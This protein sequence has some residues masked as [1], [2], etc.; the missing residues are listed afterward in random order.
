MLEITG[1]CCN[2]MEAIEFMEGLADVVDEDAKGDEFCEEYER[3][4]NRFRYEVAKGLGRKKNVARAVAKGYC[5][6]KY[7]GKCG[8]TADEPSWSYCP[9]CGTKYI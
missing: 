1:A 5:D 4:L 9:N 6:L 8:F 3:A 7:C 2:G